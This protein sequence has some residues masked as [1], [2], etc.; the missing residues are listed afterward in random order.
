M[1]S[2]ETWNGRSR[3]EALALFEVEAVL[4]GHEVKLTPSI[5]TIHETVMEVSRVVLSVSRTVAQWSRVQPMFG[6]KQHLLK[7]V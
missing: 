5:E 4:E 1:K 6:G 2:L 7:T 3:V